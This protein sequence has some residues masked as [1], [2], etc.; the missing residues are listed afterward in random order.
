MMLFFSSEEYGE[1]DVLIE[2]EEPSSR[3]VVRHSS[4]NPLTINGRAN[5]TCHYK[6]TERVQLHWLVNGK[7]VDPRLNVLYAFPNYLGLSFMVD[8]RFLDSERNMKVKCVATKVFWRLKANVAFRATFSVSLLLIS[9]TL[10][11]K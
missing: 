7:R 9:S 1:K 4:T 2:N 6:G 10:L 11:Q 5:F 8:N 3:V